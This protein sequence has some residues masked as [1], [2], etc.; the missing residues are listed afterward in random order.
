MIRVFN[1]RVM[2]IV[3]EEC[4]LRYKRML[5]R[6]G[7]GFIKRELDFKIDDFVFKLWYYL[8]KVIFE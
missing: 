6:L 5:D 1:F 2:G 4:L 7:S 3:D 8:V